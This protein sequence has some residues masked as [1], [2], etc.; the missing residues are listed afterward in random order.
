MSE[1][2]EAM[3]PLADPVIG[4]IFDSV[5]NAGLAAQSL[6]G[7]ILAE[8]GV[9]IG[10]V[11]NVT[12]QRYYKELP[13][14]RGC[15]V[16]ILVESENNPKTLVEVQMSDEPIMARNIFEYA[17]T[18]VSSVNAGTD[19]AA[20]YLNV[21]KVIV[22]N[23]CDFTVRK[24][25]NNDFI[26]PVK[27]MYTKNP[28][29]AQE[30]LNIYNVQLPNFRET[31]HDLTKP[32]HAWLFILDTATREQIT[33]KEVIKMYPELEKVV[34]TDPG[35]DQFMIRY[36]NVTSDPD[37]RREYNMYMSEKFRISA[38]MNTQYDRGIEDGM[39]EG[40]YEGKF[41]DAR[42]FLN[43]GLTIEQVA[44]G[45]MLPVETIRKIQIQ[46]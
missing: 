24:T 46:Q 30:Y 19:T 44:K 31:E 15:R 40:K 6:I 3:S 43:M 25:G 14:M 10:K 8:D 18:V 17:H 20:V 9:K 29:V 12:P 33:I 42:N 32:L 34:N 36:D 23:I 27:Q 13:Y 5:E 45:T 4:A 38:I 41:E 11:I 1:K 7:S 28:E 2:L 16:D 37:L 21:P 22:I 35:I 39:R 26:Q